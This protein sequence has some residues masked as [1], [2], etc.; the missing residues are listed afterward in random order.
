MY[1]PPPHE[2]IYC[3]RMVKQGF[4]NTRGAVMNVHLDACQ[5]WLWWVVCFLRFGVNPEGETREGGGYFS[6]F[7]ILPP[8]VTFFR[9][10]LGVS[11][12]ESLQKWAKC[13]RE[14]NPYRLLISVILIL[15][16]CKSSRIPSRF[17]SSIHSYTGTPYRFL[18]KRRK[19]VVL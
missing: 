19:V 2:K 1:N 5:A 14:S 13:D 9:R 16:C 15:V 12:N 8:P 3:F 7:G 17:F 6:F 18:N 4:D 10:A 11:P